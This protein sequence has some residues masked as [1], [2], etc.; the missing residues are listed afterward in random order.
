MYYYEY[1]L[2]VTVFRIDVVFDDDEYQ[3]LDLEM[4]QKARLGKTIRVVK[5]EGGASVHVGDVVEAF[6][7]ATLKKKSFGQTFNISNP[8]AYVS[9]LDV[10]R[11][12]VESLRSKS[13]VRLANVSAL[14]GPRIQS[15][16]RAERVLGW[17]PQRTR[18]DLETT[19][20]RMARAS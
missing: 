6:S 1:G 16:R 11:I 19:I 17:R 9:D 12:V 10:C 14:T 8:S 3:D 4:I 5:E 18:R 2:P 15:V 13:K 20:A 7:L